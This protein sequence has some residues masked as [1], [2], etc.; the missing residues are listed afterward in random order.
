MWLVRF[1]SVFGLAA[2]SVRL[3]FYLE[4][5]K[6]AGRGFDFYAYN[7]FVQYGTSALLAPHRT[8]LLWVHRLTFSRDAFQRHPRCSVH[9]YC[10]RLP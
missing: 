5:Y 6:R 3:E 7:F 8:V 2:L 1:A 4:L 10:R 9:P